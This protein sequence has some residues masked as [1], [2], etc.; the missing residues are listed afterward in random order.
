MS[1]RGDGEGRWEGV[2]GRWGWERGWTEQGH[3]IVIGLGRTEHGRAI[4]LGRARRAG[5]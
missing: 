3:C 2:M 1:G 4:G 5:R